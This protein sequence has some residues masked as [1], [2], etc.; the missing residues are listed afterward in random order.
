MER[1]GRYHALQDTMYQRRSAFRVIEDRLRS[2]SVETTY[3]YFAMGLYR[4]PLIETALL[5][6]NRQIHDESGHVLYSGYTLDFGMDIECIRPLLQ[7]LTP[8]ALSSI[9][10]LRVVQRPLPYV[11]D[12]D[13]C[14]WKNAFDFISQHMS[15][16]RLDLCV[17]GGTPKRAFPSSQWKKPEPYEKSE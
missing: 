5:H 13:R 3:K 11:K 17:C 14:E 1:S 6:V 4:T 15:L 12:F 2:R 16:T 8:A 10:S 7:D 9:K